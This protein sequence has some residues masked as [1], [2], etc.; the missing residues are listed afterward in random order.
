MS[1]DAWS[2]KISLVLLHQKHTGTQRPIRNR[3]LPK[4]SEAQFNEKHG[5]YGTLYLS[6]IKPH[7]ITGLTPNRKKSQRKRGTGVKADINIAGGIYH[8]LNMEV[9][10]QSSFG[11]HVTWCAQLYSLGE[12]PQPPP[13]P[14]TPHLDSYT[15]ALLVSKD[16]RHLFVTPWGIPLHMSG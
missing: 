13:P 16:R 11:L 3:K 15:R 1:K 7:L 2:D 5:V 8:R 4:I 9:D 6:W 10:L 12:T 14:N